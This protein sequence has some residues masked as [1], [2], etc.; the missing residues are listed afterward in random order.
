MS[1]EPQNWNILKTAS[2]NEHHCQITSRAISHVKTKKFSP[3]AG[4]LATL[5]LV[6]LIF[7]ESMKL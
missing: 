6:E 5:V 7:L 2:K 3:A 4:R 1:L